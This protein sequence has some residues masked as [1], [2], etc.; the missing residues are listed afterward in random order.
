MGLRGRV[1]EILAVTDATCKLG[2]DEEYAELRG[3]LAFRFDPAG[4]LTRSPGSRR[5]PR[6]ERHPGRPTENQETGLSW[7]NRIRPDRAQW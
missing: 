7:R 3:E 2:L 4:S 1:V 6:G 5:S